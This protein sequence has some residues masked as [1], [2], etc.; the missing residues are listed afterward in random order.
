MAVTND[1]IKQRLIGKFGEQVTNFSES[2]GMLTFEAPKEMNLKVMTFLF[3]DPELKF[4]F[5][6]TLCGVH[7]PDQKQRERTVPGAAGNQRRGTDQAGRMRE[8]HVESGAVLA[9]RARP[10]QPWLLADQR[11]TG[12]VPDGAG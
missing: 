3:D 12:H 9:G 10:D 6:T 7:Y 4:K 8:S 1:Y 5:L 11:G 2:Y